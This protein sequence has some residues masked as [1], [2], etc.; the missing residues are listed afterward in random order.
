VVAV[1]PQRS[2]WRRLISPWEYRQL[3][4]FGVTR[5]AGGCVAAVAGIVCLWY[6]VFGW[7]AFFLVLAALEFAGGWWYIAIARSASTPT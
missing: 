5:L 2:G 7:A 1:S 3:R 4:V 6:G